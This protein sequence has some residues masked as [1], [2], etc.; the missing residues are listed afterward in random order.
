MKN[1]VINFINNE[2]AEYLYVFAYETT[3][4]TRKYD[5]VG[6]E[7]LNIR[8]YT[9]D[10]IRIKSPYMLSDYSKNNLSM[11]SEKVLFEDKLFEK[12]GSDKK[13]IYTMNFMVY[14][15]IGRKKELI[16]KS[17]LYESQYL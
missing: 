9:E 5:V 15:V 14:R 2:K 13:F 8:Y 6:N 7:R 10:E 1:N 4:L 12:Y 3:I 11:Y 16:Y 17:D